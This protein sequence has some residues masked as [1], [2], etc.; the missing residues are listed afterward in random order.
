MKGNLKGSGVLL[1]M[2]ISYRGKEIFLD[3]MVESQL[4]IDS[5][6][7]FFFVLPC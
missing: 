3:S 1:V 4:N 2:W 5:R 6:D 7:V